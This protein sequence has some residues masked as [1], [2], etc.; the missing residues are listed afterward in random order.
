AFFVGS[1]EK[2]NEVLD[3]YGIQMRD[4]E[5]ART[6]HV[7]VDKY[8]ID[9]V[10]KY[11]G[12]RSAR[13]F[14]ASPISVLDDK[15]ARVWVKAHGVGKPGDGFVASAMAG[16]GEVVA[17]GESLWWHW[18]TDEQAAGSDNSRLLRLML[19]ARGKK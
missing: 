19:E 4:E 11:A 2:A 12:V 13:F 9:P 14:R 6:G 8:D 16:K 10:T 5:D 15:R 1:V 3:G 7:M 17:L 18:I